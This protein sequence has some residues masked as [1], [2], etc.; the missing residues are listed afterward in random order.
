MDFIDS[1]I[2]LKENELTK[3]LAVFGAGESGA[4]TALAGVFSEPHLF[5]TAV[6]HNPVTDLV[7]HMLFDIETRKA[8]SQ[9]ALEHD[10]RH[11]EKIEEYGDPH[12]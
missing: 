5:E 12:N 2:Y 6:V 4:L 7:Q 11:Y 3:K 10:L 1:A 8:T 9:S